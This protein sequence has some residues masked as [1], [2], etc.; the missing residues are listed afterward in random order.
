MAQ[1]LTQASAAADASQSKLALV[2]ADSHSR[3]GVIL[4]WIASENGGEVKQLS[5]TGARPAE[6]SEVRSVE[7][8]NAGRRIQVIGMQA[9][10]LQDAGIAPLLRNVERIVIALSPHKPAGGASAMADALAGA[11]ASFARQ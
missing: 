6:D 3:C 11:R 10:A 1:A 4:H 5:I 9:A 7:V 8:A 2:V